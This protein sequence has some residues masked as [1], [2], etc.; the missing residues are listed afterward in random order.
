MRKL[1]NSELERKSVEQFRKSEKSPFVVVLDN[2]RSQSN[3]GSIFRTADAFLSEAMY[4]C[5]ITATPPHREIQKTALGATESVTWKYFPKTTYAVH[6][7]REKGYKII[8]VEQVEGSISLQNMKVEKGRK[9]A[10]IFGH[11]V[12]GVDQEVLN[13][14]DQCVEIP[15]FGTKHSFNIAISVGI[16]LWELN[17][18]LTSPDINRA[19]LPGGKG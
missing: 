11:E 6:E 5:G 4:L 14:C 15:Q 3:V 18:C 7:L 8:A 10:F 16:V 12:N 19:S 1:L 9:Y 2:V 17:K 13:L